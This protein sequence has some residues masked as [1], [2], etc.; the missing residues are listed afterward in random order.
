M[1]KIRVFEKGEFYSE[2]L[3]GY[4]S[5]REIIDSEIEFAVVDREGNVIIVEATHRGYEL[6][7]I[8]KNEDD[9]YRVEVIE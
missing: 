6:Y 7:F 4:K 9:K 2:L 1:K 8:D 3:G 5:E